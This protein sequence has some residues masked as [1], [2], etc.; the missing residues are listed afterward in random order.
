VEPK[1]LT[2]LIDS[3]LDIQEVLYAICPGSGGYDAI[4]VMALTDISG[5]LKQ[6]VGIHGVREIG[7]GFEGVCEVGPQERHQVLKALNVA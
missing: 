2:P 5:R 6:K 7:I 1:E 4:F 3:I